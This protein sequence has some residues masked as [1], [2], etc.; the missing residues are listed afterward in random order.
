MPIF[1]CIKICSSQAEVYTL[2]SDI[3]SPLSTTESPFSS[4]G[5]HGSTQS[6]SGQGDRYCIL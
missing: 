2:F 6:G 1:T 3:Q 5:P 4:N